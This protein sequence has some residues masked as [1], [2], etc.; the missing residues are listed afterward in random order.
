MH[1]I[2]AIDAATLTSAW[3][4]DSFETAVRVVAFASL[5]QI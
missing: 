4:C 2:D 3:G 5:R 1:P